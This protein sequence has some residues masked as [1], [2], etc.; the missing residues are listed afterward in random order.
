MSGIDFWK[1]WR[2][3]F[4]LLKKYGLDRNSAKAFHR[5]EKVD[6]S[7]DELKAEERELWKSMGSD[8]PL[9]PVQIRWECRERIRVERLRQ[10]QL[11]AAILALKKDDISFL[12]A[13][14]IL[15]AHTYADLA[16]ML[17][18]A[19]EKSPRLIA[20]LLV[21]AQQDYDTAVKQIT[22]EEARYD[23][24]DELHRLQ[25]EKAN[26]LESLAQRYDALHGKTS[27]R[28]DMQGNIGV[29]VYLILSYI[30]QL[31]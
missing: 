22:Q 29:Q 30:F 3:A 4:L 1:D 24:L 31:F 26:I 15:E 28:P 23:R 8:A 9:D 21:R 20:S 11:F 10:D 25:K 6:T 19:E 27:R 16:R 5:L 18:S 17:A 2:Q 7:I 12:A 13:N 14:D